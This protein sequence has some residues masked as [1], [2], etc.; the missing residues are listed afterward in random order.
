MSFIVFQ[1]FFSP[2]TLITISLLDSDKLIGIFCSTIS[3]G[4][5]ERSQRMSILRVLKVLDLKRDCKLNYEI[6]RLN[7]LT[8]PFQSFLAILTLVTKVEE[9]AARKETKQ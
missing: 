5:T 9:N 6:R 3:D 4:S 1:S 2:E 8:K 7:H